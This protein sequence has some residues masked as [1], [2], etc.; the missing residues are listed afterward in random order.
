MKKEYFCEIHCIFCKLFVTDV[1]AYFNNLIKPFRRK[2]C[3]EIMMEENFRNMEQSDDSADGGF[4]VNIFIS[5]SKI[6]IY[7]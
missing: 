7:C 3:I 2:K 4:S 1:A 5:K 6:P